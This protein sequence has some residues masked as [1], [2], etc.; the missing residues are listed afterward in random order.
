M[1]SDRRTPLE[2]LINR[3]DETSDLL[4]SPELRAQLCVANE[5][6]ATAVRGGLLAA[7]GFLD[8]S[9]SCSVPGSLFDFSSPTPLNAFRRRIADIYGVR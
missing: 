7:A 5:E 2:R 8:E 6:E 4:R 9:V 3:L 1:N